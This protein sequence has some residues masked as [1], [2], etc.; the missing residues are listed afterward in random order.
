MTIRVLFIGQGLFCEGLTRLL[1][2]SPYVEIIGA[3]RTCTQARE[4]IAREA[5]DVLIVDHAQIALNPA[6]L[7]ALLDSAGSLKVISLT[8]SENK[9]VVHD[10]QLLADVTLPMLMQAL[11]VSSPKPAASRS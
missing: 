7:N 11:Q 2:E 6:E 9:M 10:R 1:S 5:A 3:V 4:R 8:L